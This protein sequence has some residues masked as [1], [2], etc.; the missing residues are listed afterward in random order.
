VTQQIPGTSDP[1]RLNRSVW[2]RGSYVREYASRQLRPVEVILLVRHRE[3]FAGRVIELGCG[4]GRVAGYFAELSDEAYGL[5]ISERMVQESARRYPAGK[6]VQ[7][8]IRD[9]A[10]FDDEYFDAVFAGYNVLDVFDDDERRASIREAR[11][12]LKQGGLYVFSSHNRAYIPR[13]R[14][15]AQPRTVDP[16]RFTFDLV[17]AP[18]RMRRH[19]ELSPLERHE[20]DYD[21]ISDGSHGFRLVHYYIAPD[22]QLRQLEEEGFEPQSCLDLDGRTLGQGDTAPDCSELHYVAR[23]R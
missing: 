9:L 20:R 10:R 2:A 18:R 16:L 4:A 19:R 3:D 7:G 6:F 15:P 23:R 11:R 12:V 1:G 14:G 13:L 17:R 22:A 8:D 5:D 21:I